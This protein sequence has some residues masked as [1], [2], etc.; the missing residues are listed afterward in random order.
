MRNILRA[1]ALA[2][3]FTP[4]IAFATDVPITAIGAVP[5]AQSS[6]GASAHVLCDQS[7]AVSIASATTTSVVPVVAGKAVYVCSI[8]VQIV[9][10]TTPTLQFEYG[11]GAT[12]TSPTVLTGAFSGVG[13]YGIEGTVG[14][15][16]RAPASNGLC[17]V[18]GGTTPVLAGFV[19]YAQF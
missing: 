7:A 14:T 1:L 17:I 15:L 10:G 11:T 5:V 8:L 2:L 6:T 18:S 3:A 16:F 13:V 4:A 12:C 9:S 19:S